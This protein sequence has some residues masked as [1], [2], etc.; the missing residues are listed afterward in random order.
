M[1]FKFHLTRNPVKN[2]LWREDHDAIEDV[3]LAEKKPTDQNIVTA[4]ESLEAIYDTFCNVH[5]KI[6]DQGVDV[7]APENLF[8]KGGRTIQVG[9]FRLVM[10]SVKALGETLSNFRKKISV[11]E[12]GT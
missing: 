11:A 9:S 7:F 3:I 5:E 2:F 10:H 1:K 12:E 6:A 8:F 4:L